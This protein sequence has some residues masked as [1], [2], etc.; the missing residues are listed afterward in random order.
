MVAAEGV[1]GGDRG[2]DDAGAPQ[3][4]HEVGQR[5]RQGGAVGHHVGD[6]GP[7][8]QV[9][10]HRG[11]HADLA[12]QR[13]GDDRQ[14]VEAEPA[15]PD[16]LLGRA[17]VGLQ[18]RVAELHDVAAPGPPRPRRQVPVHDVPAAGAE[19]QLDGGG[20]EHDLVADRHRAQ[21]PVRA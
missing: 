1:P 12:V 7:G 3:V 6:A 11:D 19:P 13:A 9:A 18:A 8:P 16:V 15:G 2:I 14:T 5:Q 17:G 21:E 4:V 20:V 10:Q